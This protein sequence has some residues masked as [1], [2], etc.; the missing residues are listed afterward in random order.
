[1]VLVS[2]DISDDK[3]RTKFARDLSKYGFRLQYSL[4]QIN[5]SEHLLDNF[6]NILENKYSSK[7]SQ[8]D[9][10]LIIRLNPNCK[11]DKYGY[12]KNEDSD[13]FVIG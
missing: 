5:N 8:S 13:Y 10:V 6:I 12:A 11:I 4:F 9:S 7:F 3:L 2:Y 1:M